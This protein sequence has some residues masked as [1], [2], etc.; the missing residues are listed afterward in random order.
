MRGLCELR[1]GVVVAEWEWQTG[2][3][4]L[5]DIT[6]PC[7]CALLATN[8]PSVPGGTTDCHR[9]LSVAATSS[10]GAWPTGRRSQLYHTKYNTICRYIEKK[11]HLDCVDLPLF[12]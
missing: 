3:D 11:K 2:S 10:H 4:S 8:V 1:H 9:K 7:M 6:R 12:V 5:F